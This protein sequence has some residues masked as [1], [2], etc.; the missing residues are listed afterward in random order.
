MDCPGW[1]R[2]TIGEAEEGDAFVAAMSELREGRAHTG[3][4]VTDVAVDAA[5]LSP[6]S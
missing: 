6:E 2:V 3:A 1:I 5:S 4:Q